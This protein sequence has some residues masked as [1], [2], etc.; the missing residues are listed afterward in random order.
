MSVSPAIQVVAIQQYLKMAK[1]R[2]TE[3][4]LLPKATVVQVD[5]QSLTVPFDKNENATANKILTAQLRQALQFAIKSYRD[6]E[7]VM[8]PK[9]LND[10]AM[11]VKNLTT[12]SKDV[13]EAAEPI[14]TPK[15]SA[16]ADVEAED[17]SFDSI[18]KTE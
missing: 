12:M 8:S 1:G 14:S 11:A 10:L 13:Y 4:L 3:S 17:V 6:G 5:G 7:T 15:P 2:T 9:E 16:D 18:Q